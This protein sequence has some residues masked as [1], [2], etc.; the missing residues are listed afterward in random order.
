MITIVITIYLKK[1]LVATSPTRG[2]FVKITVYK[3]FD[4][5]VFPYSYMDTETRFRKL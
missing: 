3:Y 4:D 1:I 5:E 2:S